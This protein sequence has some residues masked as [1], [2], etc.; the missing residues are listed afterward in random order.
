MAKPFI[1]ALKSKVNHLK[2]LEV[3]GQGKI[4]P[5][6]DFDQGPRSHTACVFVTTSC[7]SIFNAITTDEHDVAT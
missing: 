2:R 3:T 4:L 7:I 6:E 5:S 1:E